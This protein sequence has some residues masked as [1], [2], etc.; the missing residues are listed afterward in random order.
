MTVYEKIHK[1]L[2]FCGLWDDE[3]CLIL[4]S[5]RHNKQLRNILLGNVLDY[6]RDLVASVLLTAETQALKWIDQNEP[7][8]FAQ[9]ALD[10]SR[11]MS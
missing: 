11:R 2:T 3:A 4:E 1:Y 5:I 7:S 6:P 8:H 10:P 9:Y